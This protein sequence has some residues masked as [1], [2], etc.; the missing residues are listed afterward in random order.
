MGREMPEM[1]RVKGGQ[2]Q[3]GQMGTDDGSGKGWRRV[4]DMLL[5]RGQ[6]TETTGH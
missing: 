6:E 2:C 1:E 4:E 3:Q 5:G